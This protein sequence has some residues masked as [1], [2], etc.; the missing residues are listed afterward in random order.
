VKNQS[1]LKL[2]VTVSL[3]GAIG[4]GSVGCNLASGTIGER[5]DPGHFAL[6]VNNYGGTDD[7]GFENA[8]LIQGGRVT[9]NSFNQILVEAPGYFVRKD[10]KDA[11]SLKFSLRG[12][13]IDMGIG[14]SYRFRTDVIDPAKPD[15]TYFHQYFKKYRKSPVDFESTL[16]QNAL[17]DS[18][19]SVNYTATELLA[20]TEGFLTA[21][22]ARLA[23]KF[24]EIEFQTVSATGQIIVPEKT[25]AA[26]NATAEAQQAAEAAKYRK[27]QAE[28]EAAANVATA[29]GKAQVLKIETEAEANAN[30]AINASLT[31]K[32]LELKRLEVEQNRW[33][34]WNGQMAPTIQTPNV[35][36]GA[37]ATPGQ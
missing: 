33:T 7:K 9:Y 35:Q 32:V 10:F 1:G 2:A 5:V 23:E 15:Y 22:K 26:A 11:E 4:F 28:A 6:L 12:V 37:G 34:K 27:A 18:A 3:I 19:Q 14:V 31:D 36:L 29:T 21:L 25:Q 8:K 16:L 24:P 30:A 13:P 20:D 17:Q